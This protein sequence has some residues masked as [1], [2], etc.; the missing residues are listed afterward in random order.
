MSAPDYKNLILFS[1]LITLSVFLIFFLYSRYTSPGTQIF[2]NDSMH[3]FALTVLTTFY[4]A[5][6]L[7]FLNLKKTLFSRNTQELDPN[8][9]IYYLQWPFRINKFKIAFLVSTITYFVFFC[10]HIKYFYLF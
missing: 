2:I 3:S 5:I 1:T 10:I 9:L 6:I 7:F 8:K 4:I